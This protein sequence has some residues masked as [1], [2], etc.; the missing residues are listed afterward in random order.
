MN[1][2]NEYYKKRLWI[3]IVFILVSL[4]VL[5]IGFF[6][7]DKF[8]E[9]GINAQMLNTANVNLKEEAKIIIALAEIIIFAVIILFSLVDIFTKVFGIGYRNESLDIRLKKKIGLKSLQKNLEGE[10]DE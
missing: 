2:E 9:I 5:L 8:I 10:D 1:K 3:S 6:L 7:L 4:I